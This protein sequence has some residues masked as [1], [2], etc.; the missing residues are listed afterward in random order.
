M[1]VYLAT[2]LDHL[3]ESEI[4]LGI[5]TSLELAQSAV[6]VATAS[7]YSME[8]QRGNIEPFELDTMKET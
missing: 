6:D 1:T 3:C 2:I 8:Y 7:R 4:V 5:F